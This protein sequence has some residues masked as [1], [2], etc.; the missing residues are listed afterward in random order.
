[1]HENYTGPEI[2]YSDFDVVSG[3]V[4]IS[5]VYCILFNCIS[6]YPASTVRRI[7]LNFCYPTN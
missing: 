6:S 5:A 1:M 2:H 7:P 3:T 4:L